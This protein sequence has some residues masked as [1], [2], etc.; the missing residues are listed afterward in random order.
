MKTKK[1]SFHP[2]SLL[3]SNK[4]N[5]FKQKLNRVFGIILLSL[6]F[7]VTNTL[8]AQD[9]FTW[10]G[11]SSTD[12]AT[13]DNWT[14]VRGGAP[15]T[16]TYPGQT[17]LV[18]IVVIQ[19]GIAGTPS[20]YQPTLASGTLQIGVLMVSN[21]VGPVSGAT[22]TISS[23]ATLAVSGSAGTAVGTPTV[24]LKGGNIINNGSLNITSSSTS[25]NYGI[26][27]TDPIQYGS[28]TKYSYS[29]SGAL[30]ITQAAGAAA[31]SSF[32]FK[33]GSTTTNYEILFNGT[34]TLNLPTAG[35]AYA[36]TLDNGSKNAITIGGAGFT[37]GAAGTGNGIK[38]GLISM[39]SYYNYTP[40]LSINA[41]TTL[42]AV[43]ENSTGGCVSMVANNGT[44]TL[45]NNGTINISGTTT[46]T[47][48]VLNNAAS[49]SNTC[50]L[51]FN[52]A[53]IF[54]TNLA[55]NGDSRG[56]M[57]TNS[58]NNLYT[59]AA[60]NVTNSGIMT[61][62]NT[63]TGTNMG[64]AFLAQS[65]SPAITFTNNS[66]GTFE[67]SGTVASLGNIPSGTGYTGSRATTFNNSGTV[68]LLSG[69]LTYITFNNNSGGI[70]D[71]KTNSI[72]ST[73]TNPTSIGAGSILKT[74]YT[75]GLACIG[76]TLPNSA[77]L[78]AGT[79]YVF[80]GVAA[81]TTGAT[82]TAGAALTA[83]NIEINNAAGI[84]L[85][86]ATNINGVLTMTAGTLTLGTHNLTIGVLGSIT[87][88]TNIDQTGTGKIIKL[89]T[90]LENN[91]LNELILLANANELT[92]K[93]LQAG[94]IVAIYNAAGQL[95][96][97]AT[98]EGEQIDFP[99]LKG[100]CIVKVIT[101]TTTKT[102]K[103][104]L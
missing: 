60:I 48:I 30:T 79:N 101:A 81:Q 67:F 46:K 56:V 68:N 6:L 27:C 75:S 4:Q 22:L 24:I 43:L 85:S 38:N 102:A 61:L 76:G 104:V 93:G 55:V 26:I 98:S 47:P 54:S 3:R 100:L 45:T 15:G 90:A 2:L 25:V 42:T 11:S 96:K 80:N 78:D 59:S 88:E 51:N 86:N 34:T 31:S 77:L 63:Q 99:S 83:N 52:N 40:S 103:V 53:G 69:G 92:I 1:T 28:V 91:K 41:G 37:I 58:N 16:D 57:L 10:N 8:C 82:G 87:S 39:I 33:S 36:L 23:G 32:Y 5:N 64:T 7:G 50:T 17:R 94:N 9:T 62:K 70:L 19:G 89:V 44:I 84:T 73:A 18:D 66:G 97:Q 95:L 71:C 12:W 35:A 14:I 13:A 72:T 49:A 21:A 29:G 20:T 74:A 65:N